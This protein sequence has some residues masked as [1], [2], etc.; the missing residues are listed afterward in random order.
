MAD[1]VIKNATLMETEPPA[2]GNPLLATPNAFLTPHI[3][4]ATRE[5]RQRLMDTCTD[6]LRAF[7]DGKPQ[8]VV[9][10]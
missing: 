8:N 1:I 9:N 6:N 10:K 4:W 3:A 5:A 2:A 7:L